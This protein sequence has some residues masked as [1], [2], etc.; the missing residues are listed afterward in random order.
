MPSGEESTAMETAEYRQQE[1]GAATDNPSSPPQRSAQSSI[2]KDKHVYNSQIF[3]YD[4]IMDLIDEVYEE[5]WASDV[6]L[7]LIENKI[8]D[9]RVRHQRAMKS[10]RRSAAYNLNLQLTTAEGVKGMYEEYNARKMQKLE[11]LRSYS[12]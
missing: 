7:I 2:T 4:M 5:I 6:Q 1:T 8:R 11:R 12:L 10:G 9:L 3:N